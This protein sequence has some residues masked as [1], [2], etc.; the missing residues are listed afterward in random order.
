[1]SSGFQIAL[2]IMTEAARFLF[3]A[4]LISGFT[5][6]GQYPKGSTMTDIIIITELILAAKP[7]NTSNK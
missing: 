4:L 1:M 7:E 6:Q 3:L 5:Y 2:S